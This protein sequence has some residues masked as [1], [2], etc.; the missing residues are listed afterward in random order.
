MAKRVGVNSIRQMAKEQGI[1]DEKIINVDELKISI[2]NYLPIEK[3]REI[4]ILIN[5][6]S[7]QGDGDL[8]LYDKSSEDVAICY[9]IIREYTS[10]N[11]MKDEFEFY[12]CMKTSGLLDI[13]FGHMDSDE[14]DYI[15]KLVESGREDSYRVQELRG[16]MGHKIVG[17]IDLI[18]RKADDMI[19]SIKN[20]DPS[21]LD[22]LLDFI[23]KDKREEMLDSKNNKVDKEE[24]RK[25]SDEEIENKIK[26]VEDKVEDFNPDSD[27]DKKEHSGEADEEVDS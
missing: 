19:S 27:I 21:K 12:D 13:V 24:L 17:I 1:K 26:V 10:I 9:F 16:M 25:A 3:K 4:A 15:Y 14:L 8:R 18:A 6:N 11:M 2:K 22:T 20:F 7:F 23:P 5:E